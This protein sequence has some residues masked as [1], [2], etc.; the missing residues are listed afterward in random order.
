MAR[1]PS[2]GK[3]AAKN[4]RITPLVKRQ[5]GT[6][7]ADVVMDDLMYVLRDSQVRVPRPG[8]YYV[9]IYYAQKPNLLTDRYPVV[10]VTEIF[11]WGFN[12]INLHLEQPR[13]YNFSAV[14]G[15]LYELKTTEIDSVLALPLMDL[16]QNR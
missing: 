4:N 2:K 7:E 5:Y 11:E 13:R 6:E 3:K 14:A 15:G 1:K 9:F 10:A 12:G 8:K 16:K